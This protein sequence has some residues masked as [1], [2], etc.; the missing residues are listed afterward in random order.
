VHQG[1]DR[2]WNSNIDG[3]SGWAKSYLKWRVLLIDKRGLLE[4]SKTHQRDANIIE[5][6]RFDSSL[7]IPVITEFLCFDKLSVR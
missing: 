2:R 7:I 4:R 5:E 1:R 3:D 6:V